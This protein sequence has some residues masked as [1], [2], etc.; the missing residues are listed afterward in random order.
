MGLDYTRIAYD[1]PHNLRGFILI[2]VSM[3]ALDAMISRVAL[4]ALYP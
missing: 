1:M 4:P 2:Q 3:K